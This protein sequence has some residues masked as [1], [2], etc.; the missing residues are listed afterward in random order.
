MTARENMEMH[1]K[2][3]SGPGIVVHTCNPSYSENRRI[4]APGETRI[5]S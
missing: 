2:K 5:K 4:M 1:E 3:Q